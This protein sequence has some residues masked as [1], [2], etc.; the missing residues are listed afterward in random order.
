ML[1]DLTVIDWTGDLPSGPALENPSAVVLHYAAGTTGGDPANIL[2]ELRPHR[3]SYHYLID[4]DGSIYQ[5]VDATQQA[6]HAGGGREIAGRAANAAS[7]GLA[8]VNIGPASYQRPGFIEAPPPPS[9][10]SWSTAYWEPYTAEAI[11]SAGRL[12]Q[13]LRAT[14]PVALPFRDFYHSELTA[15]WA[16]PK[17]D[18]GPAFPRAD[19]RRSAGLSRLRLS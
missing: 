8:F 12:V 5:L 9:L 17:G 18:P 15:D 6:W 1:G 7:W 4:R 19:F 16:T 14:Y 10:S 3:A 13:Q 2:E 11:A